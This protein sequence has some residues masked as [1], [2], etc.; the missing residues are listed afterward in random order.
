MLKNLVSTSGVKV[1][2]RREMGGVETN[3]K[4]INRGGG[5]Q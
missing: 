3:L 4:D 1:G 2:V 5:A